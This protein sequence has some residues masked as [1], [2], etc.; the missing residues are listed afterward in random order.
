MMKNFIFME[1]FKDWPATT[2][3]SQNSINTFLTKMSPYINDIPI[4]QVG[5]SSSVG[6]ANSSF[7][8]DGVKYSGFYFGNGSGFTSITLPKFAQG[9]KAR[10]YVGGRMVGTTFSTSVSFYTLTANS[11]PSSGKVETTAGSSY[12]LEFV[13]DHFTNKVSIYVNKLKKF[14]NTLTTNEISTIAKGTAKLYFG[15]YGV[16]YSVFAGK[17]GLYTDFY[18]ATET[19]DGDTAPDIEVFGPVSVDSY[20]VTSADAPGFA[21]DAESI[22]A[23]LAAPYKDT[24][25]VKDQPVYTDNDGNVGKFTFNT[26]PATAKPIAA[27]CSVYAMRGPSSGATLVTKVTDGT[28]ELVADQYVPTLTTA[29]VSPT[30]F[31]DLTPKLTTVTPEALNK[32]VVELNSK[33]TV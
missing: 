7:E 2:P 27:M 28:N 10:T 25:S 21:T 19:W 16:G 3:A 1:G 20:S 9:S 8:L 29:T 32:I 15:C 18:M 12:Y 4:L 30:V 31:Y 24:Y 33:E 13:I 22:P 11:A 26:V 6:V 17:P 14:E 23:A 5:T